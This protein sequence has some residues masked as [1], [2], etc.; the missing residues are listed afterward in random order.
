[1]VRFDLSSNGPSTVDS[2]ALKSSIMAY[3]LPVLIGG[4]LPAPPLAPDTQQ[5]GGRLANE[6]K[7]GLCCPVS[8][9]DL[10]QEQVPRC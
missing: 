4:L 9:E 8:Y 3:S 6:A 5:A 2:L 7:S 10:G 1:M